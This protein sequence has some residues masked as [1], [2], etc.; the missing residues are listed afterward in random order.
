MV[1]VNATKK[2]SGRVT[3][4]VRRG[5]GAR[6]GIDAST[7]GSFSHKSQRVLSLVEGHYVSQCFLSSVLHLST[8]RRAPSREEQH[9]H[10]RCCCL[11]I[12]EDAQAQSLR[13]MATYHSTGSKMP[14]S[15]QARRPCRSRILT[16]QVRQSLN[17]SS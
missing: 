2:A 15:R 9:F 4:R 17:E 11:R 7:D 14:S 12:V 1:A 6:V 16:E 5:K 8:A 13:T 10:R 3:T